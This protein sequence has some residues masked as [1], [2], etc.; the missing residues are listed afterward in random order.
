[1]HDIQTKR[2][3]TQVVGKVVVVTMFPWLVFMLLYHTEKL[4]ALCNDLKVLSCMGHRQVTNY[5]VCNVLLPNNRIWMGR[6]R[7]IWH[8]RSMENEPIM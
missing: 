3:P 2:E 1:M 7:Q 8:T 4:V 5:Y 6:E